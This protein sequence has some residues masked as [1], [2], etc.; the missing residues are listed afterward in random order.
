MNIK[1]M[2]Y[3]AAKVDGENYWD[4]FWQIN[5]TLLRNTLLF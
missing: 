2:Y 4:C 3:E 1:N 5:I